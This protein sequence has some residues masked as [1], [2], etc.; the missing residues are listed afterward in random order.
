[1]DQRSQRLAL[2][3]EIWRNGLISRSELKKATGL[4]LPSVTRLVQD[5]KNAGVIVE[6]DKANPP[7]AG[8][9]L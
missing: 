6:T 5:L 8:N 3:S 7:A 9:H 2:L 4:T 1:M